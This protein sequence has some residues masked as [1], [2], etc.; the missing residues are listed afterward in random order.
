VVATHDTRPSRSIYLFDHAEQV[1]ISR[2][3]DWRLAAHRLDL[4]RAAALYAARLPRGFRTRSLPNPY[5]DT[6]HIVPAELARFELPAG[7]QTQRQAL[8]DQQDAGTPLTPAERQGAAGPVAL[9]ELRSL[10]HLRA[11]PLAAP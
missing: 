8:L 5:L 1:R 2:D 6:G 10:L 3:L 7:V 11:R 9:A 4:L